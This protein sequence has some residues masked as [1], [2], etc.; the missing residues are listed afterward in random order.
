M[1]LTLVLPTLEK[2]LCVPSLPLEKELHPRK[3]GF[4]IISWERSIINEAYR[5]IGPELIHH[6]LDCI[7]I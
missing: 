1:Y 5:E 6:R 4:V 7:E 3:F 2:S